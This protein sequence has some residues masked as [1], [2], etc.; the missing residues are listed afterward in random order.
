MKN[1][2][3][4]TGMGIGY[5]VCVV[6]HLI[7]ALLPMYVVIPFAEQIFGSGGDGCCHEAGILTH[8]VGDLL[9][10]IM[11]L[12][13]VALLTW[14]GHKLVRYVR[15][16]CGVVHEEDPCAGCLHKKF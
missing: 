5:A 15:C 2:R 14:L 6:T 11:I 7:A 16:K 10:L 13:P 9:I 12:V 8:I 3:L 4:F 1:R